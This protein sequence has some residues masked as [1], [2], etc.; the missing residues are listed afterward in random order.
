MLLPLILSP[1][2]TLPLLLIICLQQFKLV[3][4]KPD[5]SILCHPLQLSG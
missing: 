5:Q 4:C 2:L 3:P 1:L